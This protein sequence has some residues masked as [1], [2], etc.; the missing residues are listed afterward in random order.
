MQNTSAQSAQTTQFTERYIVFVKDMQ[1][2]EE[3]TIAKMGMPNDYANIQA[4]A[5][6]KYKYPQYQIHMVYTQADLENIIATLNRW[7][8]TVSTSQAIARQKANEVKIQ[9]DLMAREEWERLVAA[10]KNR[11]REK[12]NFIAKS[13]A[14]QPKPQPQQPAPTP[15]MASAPQPQPQSH[16]ADA[17]I[18]QMMQTK[19]TT[20]GDIQRRNTWAI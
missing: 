8:G 3:F 16:S 1:T 20:P 13:M 6:E 12:Q 7:Y 14:T 18:D 4:Q 9:E 11:Q 19:A 2:S 17:L 10:H 5:A 15:T